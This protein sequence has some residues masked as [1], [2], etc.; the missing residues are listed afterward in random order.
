MVPMRIFVGSSSEARPVAE[1]IAR[2]LE[3]QK[4]I[5][6]EVWSDLFPPGRTFLEQIEM[7]PDEVVAAVLLATPDVKST[8]GTHAGSMPVPNILFE[9]GF[10]AARLG[11]GRVALV[12][13]DELD[14]PSDL[15][16]MSVIKDV[17][18][19]YGRDA[20]FLL[21][22]DTHLKLLAWLR[23]LRTLA[24]GLPAMAQV[25]GYSGTWDVRN[26]FTRWRDHDVA[27]GDDVFFIGKT[28]LTLDAGGTT[29]SGVQVGTL[30]VS[31]GGY[32]VEREVVN[33][34]VH[35][36]VDG[37]GTLRLRLKMVRSRIVPGSEHGVE[38]ADARMRGDLGH[39]VFPLELRPATDEV[40]TLRGPHD[41]ERAADAHLQLA[42]E[43]FV[44][45]GL[46]GA[47]DLER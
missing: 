42:Q 45:T 26:R 25:H 30:S 20:A 22:N 5:Q 11:R 6:T 7:L 14:L 43:K 16:G 17:Q 39:V 12:E 32:Q 28:F 4:G 10:L 38:H 15:N 41:F 36:S 31:M 37:D 9:F 46:T 47:A 13:V 24:P 34:I 21:H 23:G 33:E 1:Q 29:G 2:L 18:H 27:P 44:H 8:R 40:R 3:E 19:T 35:A